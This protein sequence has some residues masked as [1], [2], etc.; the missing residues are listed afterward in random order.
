MTLLVRDEED[1]LAANLDFHLRQ[2]IDFFVVT[3]NLST[4]GSRDI[5]EEYVRRGVAV[6]LRESNDDY[7]QFRWVTKMARMATLDYG[8]DWVINNDADEFWAAKDVQGSVKEVLRAIPSNVESLMVMRSNFVPVDQDGI[9]FF[10]ERMTLCE[11][12]PRNTDGLPLPPK[13]CHRGF[14]DIE[15]AQGNHGVRRAG[16]PLT[17]LPG[18]LR[19]MHVPLRSYRQFE[20]KIINGGA[21]YARNMELS[22][23]VGSTWRNLHE[24][25]QRGGLR[26]RYIEMMLSAQEIESGLESGELF[27]D[28]TVLN[29]LRAPR[30]ACRVCGA[31]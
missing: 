2:G 12:E 14:E 20:N 10:A 25:W 9:G 31:S 3:D 21:A 8:A 4:D 17:A 13:V 18:P 7:S 30:R 11:R 28:E 29:A 27:Y 22:P 1:I 6:C 5:I 19:I 16:K 26:T 15:V 23:D 24:V